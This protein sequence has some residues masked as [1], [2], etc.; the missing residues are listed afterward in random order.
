MK[1][2]TE[3]KFNRVNFVLISL[4]SRFLHQV[5]W[6]HGWMD[7]WKLL[8]TGKREVSLEAIYI[9]EKEKG[10][11]GKGRKKK[12]AGHERDSKERRRWDECLLLL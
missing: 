2:K 7:E 1:L 4:S 11:R 8:V 3:E 5:M 12:R 10:K 6:M 9:L